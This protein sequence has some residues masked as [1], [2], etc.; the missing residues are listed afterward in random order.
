MT[1]PISHTD[2]GIVK[3]SV[4]VTERGQ[5][6]VGLGRYKR[7]GD[8]WPHGWYGVGFNGEHVMADFPE[9]VSP[10]INSYINQTYAEEEE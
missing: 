7:T 8:T 9:L 5:L 6:A 10:S 2:D 1:E 3:G 4:F